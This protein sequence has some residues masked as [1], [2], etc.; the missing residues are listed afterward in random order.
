M[1]LWV[2]L[3]YRLSMHYCNMLFM[4][5]EMMRGATIRGVS[6][7]DCTSS[8]SRI[9]VSQRPSSPAQFTIHHA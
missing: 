3:I 4:N 5:L 8:G 9:G 6:F 7:L 1:R 2:F